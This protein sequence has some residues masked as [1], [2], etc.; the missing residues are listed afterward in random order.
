MTHDTPPKRITLEE[1]QAAVDPRLV[2][3]ILRDFGTNFD[4]VYPVGV[5][6]RGVGPEQ[7]MIGLAIKRGHLVT[8]SHADAMVAA[9]LREAAAIGA[10]G[11]FVKAI[12]LS[13]RILALIPQ[14]ASAA[15]AATVQE[16]AAQIEGMRKALTA[17][18]KRA[19]STRG[20]Q[21]YRELPAFIVNAVRAAL[22]APLPPAPEAGT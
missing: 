13:E 10:D 11:A 5:L 22:Q 18:Q 15:L 20:Q 21:A 12:G 19:M 17:M 9:A 14:P 1:A 7:S 8:R 3:E 2:A 16:Q 4:G 6:A